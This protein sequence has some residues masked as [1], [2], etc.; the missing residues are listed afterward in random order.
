VTAEERQELIEFLERDQL[1][2][3]RSRPLPRARVGRRAS[4][5]LWALRVFALLMAVLV[6]Y[7]FVASLGS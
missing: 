7:T 3:D 2:E 5:A 1:V 4:A 6:V